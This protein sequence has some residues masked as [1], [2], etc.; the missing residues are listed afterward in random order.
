MAEEN[1]PTNQLFSVA[2][3]LI[4]PV[5]NDRPCEVM[6]AFLRVQSG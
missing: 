5:I 1:F 6:F 3:K 4:P 2:L